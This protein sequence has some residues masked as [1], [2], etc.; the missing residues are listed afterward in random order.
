MKVVNLATVSVVA[1]GNGTLLLTE[2]QARIATS[3]GLDSVVVNPSVDIVL[4]DSGGSVV[5][6][7]VPDA[8]AGTTSNSPFVCPASTPTVISHRSGAL[9]AISTSG[10]ATVKVGLAEVP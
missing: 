3:E 4:V 10:T 9:R 5:T 2:A 6:S 8:I 1:T 7:S